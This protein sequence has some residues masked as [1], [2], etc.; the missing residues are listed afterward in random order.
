MH[1]LYKVALLRSI[2]VV[3]VL[4]VSLASAQTPAQP[5]PA[6]QTLGTSSSATE[7]IP[8]DPSQNLAELRLMIDRGH[9]ADA[10]KQINSPKQ[11][12]LL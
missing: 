5:V 10:L 2:C 3:T 8:V 12:V 4:S 7:A 6:A 11:M 1:R 9:A